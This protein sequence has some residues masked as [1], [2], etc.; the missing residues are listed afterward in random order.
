MPET[1]NSMAA[2]GCPAG[3][4]T[5]HSTR[6]GN[7]RSTSPRNPHQH[8]AIPE[9]LASSSKLAQASVTSSL[10]VVTAGLAGS[11]E[12]TS[13]PLAPRKK[14]SPPSAFM[15]RICTAI[16]RGSGFREGLATNSR[17]DSRIIRI[18]RR[19]GK[20]ENVN[21]RAL[22]PVG[23]L[24][25]TCRIESS[26]LGSTSTSLNCRTDLLSRNQLPTAAGVGNSA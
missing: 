2:N 17:N 23:V 6:P 4:P 11:D 5:R 15:R 26:S 18:D 20:H 25:S 1:P 12:T 14:R 16:Q 3:T 21:E 9:A 24:P 13:R 19:F 7:S 10:G 22:H 8:V